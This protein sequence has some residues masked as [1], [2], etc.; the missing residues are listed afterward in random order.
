MLKS[1]GAKCRR[2][3]PACLSRLFGAKGEE[4]VCGGAGKQ[5]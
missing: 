3:A 4:G 2:F 1:A 5:E